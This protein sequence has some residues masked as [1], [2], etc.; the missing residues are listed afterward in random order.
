[1]N[2]SFHQLA[3]LYESSI[4][5]H[6]TQK[7]SIVIDPS[8]GDK[9]FQTQKF[10]KEFKD[11]GGK[12]RQIKQVADNLIN[13]WRAAKGINQNIFELKFTIKVNLESLPTEMQS[14]SNIRPRTAETMPLYGVEVLKRNPPV[15]LLAIK[16]PSSL[17]KK[18][19]TSAIVWLRAFD[20]YTVYERILTQLR[21][22]M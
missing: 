10:I 20:D 22:G 11:L 16:V 7:Q 21:G 14:L 6:T 1:M 2:K 5:E 4:L 18:P 9:E 13:S 8:R 3:E 17:L 12:S 15:H 19:N